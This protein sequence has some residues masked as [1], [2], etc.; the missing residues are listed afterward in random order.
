LIEVRNNKAFEGFRTIVA[1]V[2]PLALMWMIAFTLVRTVDRCL[3]HESAANRRH[4]LTAS[5]GEA[6]KPP[7]MSSVLSMMVMTCACPMCLMRGKD[8][9]E[10]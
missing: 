1:S 6:Y 4:R 5:P 8:F 3:C 2:T 9:A 7:P 10:S